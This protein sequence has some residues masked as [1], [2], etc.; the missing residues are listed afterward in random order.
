MT[1]EVFVDGVFYAP[2]KSESEPLPS[3]Y[4]SPHFRE[5][6][7]ACNHCGDLGPN[8]IDAEL[9]VV[10][11]RLREDLGDNPV[12][13]N[14]GYRCEIHNTNVGS[15]ENS[16]HRKGTAADIVVKNVTPNNVHAYLVGKY[17]NKYGI[18]RYSSF[19]HI[20]VRQQQARW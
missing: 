3:G 8:G 9:I 11:E 2:A 17:P 5:T 18:G 7:F 12:T 20:D 14:S 6:E 15:T 1:H 16:Q 4:L 19:T 10:L 13:I